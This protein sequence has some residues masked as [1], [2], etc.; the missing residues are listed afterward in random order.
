M[1]KIVIILSLLVLWACSNPKDVS[2]VDRFK[3]V[4]P[5]T[6]KVFDVQ[7]GANEL[8]NP[9]SVAVAGNTMTTTNAMSPNNFTT[10]DIATGRI[11]KHWGDRGQGP[12]EFQ[13]VVSIYNNYS[14]TGL[15]IWDELTLKLYYSSNSDLESDSVNFHE[16]PTG[17]NK[18]EEGLDVRDAAIQIDTFMFLVTAGNNNKRFSL[19]DLKNNEVKETGDFPIENINITDSKRDANWRNNAYQG[20]IIYNR[21]LKKLVYV[22]INSEMFEIYNVNG[23]NIELAMGSYTTTPK[24]REVAQNFGGRTGWM[25]VN[26]YLTNGKGRNLWATTSNENIFILYQSYSKKELIDEKLNFPLNK[27]DMVLVFDWDGKPVKIYELDC[28]PFS[29]TYD[30]ARNRLWAIHHNED[31]DPEIIY[32]EL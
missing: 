11:I 23:T 15:N 19:V 24:Y 22:S 1:R 30:K 21:S 16:I 2:I 7:N 28:V 4:Q 13:G 32:F 6:H 20:N 9:F 18:R 3:I 5:I 27:A 29:I 10:I 17:I 14:E 26:E 12:N 8:L 25:G 31:L